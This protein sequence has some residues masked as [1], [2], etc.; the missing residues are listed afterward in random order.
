MLSCNL[1][2]QSNRSSRIL[3]CDVRI[4]ILQCQVLG[5][6][7]VRLFCRVNYHEESPCRSST[8]IVLEVSLTDQS[9]YWKVLCFLG[10]LYMDSHGV[11][12]CTGRASCIR[13]I[14]PPFLIF[15]FLN[16]LL[17]ETCSNKQIVEMY[18]TVLFPVHSTEPMSSSGPSE[19]TTTSPVTTPDSNV[20]TTPG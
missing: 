17:Y 10:L 5:S 4:L 6:L 19:T 13:I 14:E 15:F 20:P 7:L 12:C 2:L 11:Y 1:Q 8:G 3:A 16:C 9:L 18:T